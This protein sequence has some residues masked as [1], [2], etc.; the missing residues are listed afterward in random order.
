M[1]PARPRPSA[2]SQK[3]R[4][5]RSVCMFEFMMFSR[6][7]L[8]QCAAMYGDRVN[9]VRFWAIFIGCVVCFVWPRL[10]QSHTLVFVRSDDSS[11]M[12]VYCWIC[13]FRS[14]RYPTAVSHAPQSC[15]STVLCLSLEAH[16]ARLL[17]I[18]D[19]GAFFYFRSSDSFVGCLFV[20]TSI[21]I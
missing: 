3:R 1:K 20:H 8:S 7:T 16:C 14:V 17:T 10:S 5:R 9:L 13:F 19:V 21:L 15:F 11:A 18:G 2:V 4:S 12:I 6:C